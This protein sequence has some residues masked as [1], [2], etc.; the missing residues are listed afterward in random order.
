MGH[1]KSSSKKEVYSDTALKHTHTQNKCEKMWI[2]NLNLHLK[3]LA[4]EMK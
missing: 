1:G 4:K 2:N 3:K